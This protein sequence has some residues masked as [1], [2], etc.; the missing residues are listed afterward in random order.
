MESLDKLI[1][2]PIIV[3]LFAVLPLPYAYYMLLRLV[4]P[5]FA[6]IFAIHAYNH[7]KN[8]L[9]P[10]LM[11][12]MALLYNPFLPVHLFKELWIIIN[13]LSATIFYFYKNTLEPRD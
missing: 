5:F 7:Q 12:A 2:V 8:S 6:V 3:L 11:G 4:V 10:Y 1:W 13:L 9:F